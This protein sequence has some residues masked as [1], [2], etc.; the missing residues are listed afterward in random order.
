MPLSD[1]LPFFEEAHGV[2]VHLD[3]DPIDA[4]VL[5]RGGQ[6]FLQPTRLG[7]FAVTSDIHRGSGD[8]RRIAGAG[9]GGERLRA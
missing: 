7:A 3:N 5:S 8:D 6:S 4:F 9:S 1:P 2:L